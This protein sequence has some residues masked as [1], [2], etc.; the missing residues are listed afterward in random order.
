M[1]RHIVA[2]KLK[3]TDPA[4]RRAYAE[5]IKSRLE[6]LV[7]VVPGVQS[8]HVGISQ[9]LV[10]GH[11]DAVLVGEYATNADLEAYQVHPD[12]VAASQYVGTFLEGR[13][14]VDYELAE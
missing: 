14:I 11:W 10:D 13:A 12:H 5:K 7:G 3:S 8:L 2:F 4:E 6:S 9:G 1:I